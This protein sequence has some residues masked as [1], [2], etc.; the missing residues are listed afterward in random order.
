MTSQQRFNRAVVFFAIAVVLLFT[1]LVL[2][3]S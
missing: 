1:V 2:R 3:M